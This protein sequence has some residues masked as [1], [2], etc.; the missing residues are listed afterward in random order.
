M[1]WPASPHILPPLF[2]HSVVNVGPTSC[3]GFNKLSSSSSSFTQDAPFTSSVPHFC[4]AP[5]AVWMWHPFQDQLPTDDF[6][7]HHHPHSSPVN[8]TIIVAVLYVSMLCIC[9]CLQSN[10]F[11]APKPYE[12]RVPATLRCEADAC[13][14]YL[15]LLKVA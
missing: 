5:W 12:P 3:H 4:P 8:C 7:P 9:R 15:R 13:L 11:S 2:T 6:A 14:R 1:S 10:I